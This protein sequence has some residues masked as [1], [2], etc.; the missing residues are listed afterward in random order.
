MLYLKIRQRRVQYIIYKG[1]FPAQTRKHNSAH[2]Q[3]IMRF[4]RDNFQADS[5]RKSKGRMQVADPTVANLQSL[6]T[7]H[8]PGDNVEV[9]PYG[10]KLVE[11]RV[12]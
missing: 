7:T 5:V 1:A 11:I 12:A 6:S 3:H 9:R 4:R 8:C 10:R 2:L